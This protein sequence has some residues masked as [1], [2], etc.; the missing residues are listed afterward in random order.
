MAGYST[1]NPP[2][3]IGIGVQGKYR[4]WRYASV[5][6]ASLVVVSGYFTNAQK[7]GMKA[8]DIVEIIDNDSTNKTTSQAT[9]IAINADGSAN[10][11]D[12]VTVGGGG[13]AS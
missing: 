1:S 9:V 10:L 3:L 12:A 2:E 4:T 7:L 13:D 5:D 6:A 8:E 11:S